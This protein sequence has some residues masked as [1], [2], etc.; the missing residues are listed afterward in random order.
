MRF[1]FAGAALATFLIAGIAVWSTTAGYGAFVKHNP[2]HNAVLLQ[3]F[4]AVTSVTGL[5][6]VAVVTEQVHVASRW[7]VWWD[8]QGSLLGFLEFNTDISERKRAEGDLRILSGQLLRLRDDERRHIARELHDG[9]GQIL[10][11]L[12]LQLA[13]IEAE[14]HNLSPTAAKACYDC[15]E[16]VQQMSKDLRTMS[17]LL[18][19]P[20]AG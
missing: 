18:H 10:A 8:R 3:A 15:E 5:I 9:S 11:A 13:S 7:S 16:L 14:A 2:L 19:P 4:I 20:A 1:R 6:L 17:H 12:N